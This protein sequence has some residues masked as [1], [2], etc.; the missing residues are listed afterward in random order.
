MHAKNRSVAKGFRRDFHCAIIYT[1][2]TIQDLKYFLL[3]SFPN[4]RIY[5]FGSRTRGDAGVHSDVDIAIEGNTSL[6]KRLARIRFAIEESHIPYK[7]DLVDLS[8]APYLKKIV[9]EEGIRWH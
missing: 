8:K 3:T 1:M 9:Y 5:L 2:K 4:E 6:T 7:V